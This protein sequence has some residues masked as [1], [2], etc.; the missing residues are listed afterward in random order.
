MSYLP[1]LASVRVFEAVARHLSFTRAAVELGMTQAAVS[2]QIKLLEERVGAA[3]FLRLGRRVVLSEVGRRLA[4]DVIQAFD[5]MRV[6]FA[7]AQIQLSGTLTI[8]TLPTFGGQWLAPHIGLFQLEHPNVAVRIETTSSEADF[9][10]KDYDVAILANGQAPNAEFVTHML[11]RT[12]FAPI[13]TP[14]FIAR[15][16]IKHPSDLLKAPM[17]SATDPWMAKWF[18]LVGINYW[19]PEKAQGAVLDSQIMEAA[20]VLAGRGYALMTPAFFTTDFA[21]GRLVQPFPETGWDGIKY[22]L[23]YVPSRRNWPK[24]KAF[25]EW[26]LAATARLRAGVEG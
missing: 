25:R 10:H 13:M 23:G 24:V 20:A 22:H 21:S 3:L 16:N 2:Y 7:Q 1:P 6:G 18:A 4:P 14:E 11:L 15:H 19:P 9:A 12:E 26:I 8:L 5:L 17:I